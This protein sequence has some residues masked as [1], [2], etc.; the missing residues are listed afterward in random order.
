MSPLNFP[1]P[2]IK[3]SRKRPPTGGRPLTE[4][5]PL[6]FLCVGYRQVNVS[7]YLTR[8][9]ES[10]QWGPIFRRNLTEQE[11]NQFISLLHTL[12]QVAFQR[13]KQ[14]VRVWRA[15]E[16][17]AFSVSSFY[18]V[19]KCISPPS[20]TSRI[21]KMNGLLRFRM[22]CFAW[23]YPHDGQSTSP[24]DNFSE[25]L[26]HVLGRRGICRSSFVKMQGG[27]RG[28]VLCSQTI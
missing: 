28:V 2:A 8:S 5:F 11:E 17:G 24:K 1:L 15:F 20:P 14:I 3:P 7:Y 13:G 12:S 27:S 18:S 26:S 25:C 4:Q 16:H 10:I 23:G 22:D 19:L 9:G 21:W 6:L